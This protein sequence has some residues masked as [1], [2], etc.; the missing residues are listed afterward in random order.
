MKRTIIIIAVLAVIGAGVWW[1]T[2]RAKVEEGAEPEPVAVEVTRGDLRVTVSA[3]GVLE[4]L[5]TVEVKSRSG[6]EI[7]ALFVEA[8][9]YV[10]AGQLIAQLDPTE[11]QGKV[12]QAAAQVRS[13]QARVDQASYSARAQ[14][15]Q[16]ETGIQEAQATLESAKA[17]LAQARAQLEQTRETTEQ[18]IQQA[19]A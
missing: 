15:V 4:P 12:D 10:K 16:T 17:R 7:A 11:L 14:V 9:D 8:G 13:A 1:L 19:Q 2:H 18:Q 3:T 5:T 6:G